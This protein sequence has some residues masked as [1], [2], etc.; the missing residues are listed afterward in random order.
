MEALDSRIIAKA[1]AIG[2]AFSNRAS[3]VNLYLASCLPGV[4]VLSAVGN[5]AATSGTKPRF[6]KVHNGLS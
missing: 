2:G 4:T 6:C 5:A 1:L 3:A